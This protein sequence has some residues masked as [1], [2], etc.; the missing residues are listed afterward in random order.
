MVGVDSI[1]G[2][3]GIGAVVAGHGRHVEVVAAVAILLFSVRTQTT[4][5]NRAGRA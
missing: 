4:F 1:D 3:V 5:S 2:D